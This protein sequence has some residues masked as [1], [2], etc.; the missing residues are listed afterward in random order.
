MP[1]SDKEA[2]V[3]AVWSPQHILT[4]TTTSA[5]LERY[6]SPL[7]KTELIVMIEDTSGCLAF[8]TIQFYVSKKFPIYIP[9]IFAPKSSNPQN[10]IFR[11][12]VTNKVRKINYVK[13]FNRWGVLVYERNNFPTKDEFI[14]FSKKYCLFLLILFFDFFR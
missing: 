5:I 8:D 12:F 9:N 10:T 2:I 6:V 4:D 3:N 14:E 1:S 11:P 13:I 7:S